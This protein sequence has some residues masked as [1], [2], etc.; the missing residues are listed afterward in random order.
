M[1]FTIRPH[2]NSLFR[3][4]AA[5]PCEHEE[6]PAVLAVSRVI[7]LAIRSRVHVTFMYDEEAGTD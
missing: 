7:R 5:A 6:E 4:D 2:N 3:T 1:R